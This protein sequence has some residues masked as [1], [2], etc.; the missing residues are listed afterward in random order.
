MHVNTFELRPDPTGGFDFVIDGRFLR[1]LVFAPSNPAHDP[2]TLLR[3]GS[4]LD[5]ALE[6]IRRLKGEAPADLDGDRV[7]LYFCSSC[8][9]EGCGGVNVRVTV[10]ANVVVWSDF[11]NDPDSE[12]D[13]EEDNEPDP[14]DDIGPFTFERAA[15]KKALDDLGVYLRAVFAEAHSLT[16]FPKPA[17]LGIGAG[18]SRRSLRLHDPREGLQWTVDG[19]PL[20][21]ILQKSLGRVKSKQERRRLSGLV[22][23]PVHER[24]TPYGPAGGEILEM[25]LG[26]RAFAEYP[27]RVPLLVGE[28]LKVDRGAITARVRRLERTVLWDGFQAHDTGFAEPFHLFPHGLSYRFDLQQYDE[29]LRQTFNR[30]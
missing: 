7:W 27:G 6:Q 8:L 1:G 25:L 26:Q 4:Y 21:R 13:P 15:Y 19:L 17:A 10:S 5:A 24:G 30:L 16:A 2:L 14:L 11:T 22:H 20:A 23:S 18:V 9:D 12:P 29:L 28:H 3:R